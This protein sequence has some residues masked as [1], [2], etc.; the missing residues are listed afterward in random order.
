MNFDNK[1]P[2]HVHHIEKHL[3]AGNYLV[4][5]PQ[6]IPFLGDLVCRQLPFQTQALQDGAGE[7]RGGSQP[8]S[9]EGNSQVGVYT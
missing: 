5:S 6:V 2:Q 7:H 3:I 9:S 4:F 1:A 8:V